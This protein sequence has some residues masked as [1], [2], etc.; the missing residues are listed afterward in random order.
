MAQILARDACDACL[1]IERFARGPAR[2]RRP[3]SKDASQASRVA[4][5]LEFLTE[6]ARFGSGGTT[7][8]NTMDETDE[9]S[10][11]TRDAKVIADLCRLDALG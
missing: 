6:P 3:I 5:I 4:E 1:L 10:G 9:Q 8:G 11:A 7:R 2:T